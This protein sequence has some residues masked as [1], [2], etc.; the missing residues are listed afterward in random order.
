MTDNLER[1]RELRRA[2][3]LFAAGVEDDK[4]LEIPSLFPAWS[5]GAVSYRAGDRVRSG[6]LLYKCL[7]AHVSQGDWTPEAAVSLWVR[8]DNPAEEWPQ[9]RQPQGAHDAYGKGAKVSHNGTHWVSTADGNVW[10]PGA[11]GWD[12]EK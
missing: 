5:A 4:A 3:E 12:K 11:Y 8:L 2:M 10:E 6:A 7:T 9:W 1:L